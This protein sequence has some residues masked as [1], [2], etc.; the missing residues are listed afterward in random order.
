MRTT[1]II[2]K[3]AKKR[4]SVSSRS[5]NVSK[6]ERFFKELVLFYKESLENITQSIK[7]LANI[8]KDFPD[9]YETFKKLQKNP[10]LLFKLKDKLPQDE[11][12]ILLEV[13]LRASTLGQ[14]LNLLNELTYREKMILIKDINEFAKVIGKRLNK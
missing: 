6:D 2:R 3:M 10:E 12:G 5:R 7:R 9:H 4:R 8:Q 11:Q 14:R 13:F 1:K